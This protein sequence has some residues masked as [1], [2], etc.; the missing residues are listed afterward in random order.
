MLKKGLHI[1]VWSVLGVA[2]CTLLIAA[3]QKKQEKNCAAIKI[4]IAGTHHHVFVDTQDI[5]EVLT[6]NGA[7]KDKEVSLI[8]LENIETKLEKDPWVKKADLFFDNQQVLHADIEEREPIARVF[9]LQANSYYI[10]SSCNR[11]PLSD[12][13]SARI[14]MFTSFPSDKKSLSHPDSLVLCD[15][16]NIAAYIQQDSFL[17]NQVAQVNITPQRTYEIIPVVGDQLIKLGN[18]EELPEKFSKLLLFYKQVW[19]KSGFEKYSVIDL[20]YDDQVVATKRNGTGQTD[21]TASRAV[22]VQ[23]PIGSNQDSVENKATA[24]GNIKGVVKKENTAHAV[25]KKNMTVENA[26]QPKAIMK[27]E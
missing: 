16:K 25:I 2:T 12:R 18:A 24:I 3:M 10:D 26:K 6:I 5:M 19:S 22:V 9:T 7:K 21:T 27:K 4:G 1:L 17:L 15:I 23:A 13:L 8:D 20:Q 14:P 11:L